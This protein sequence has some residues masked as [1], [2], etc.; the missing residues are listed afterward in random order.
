MQN[1]CFVLVGNA[2]G[3]N[4]RRLA[5][6]I[7]SGFQETIFSAR[8]SSY[9]VFAATIDL[10]ISLVCRPKPGRRVQDNKIIADFRRDSGPH[11]PVLCLVRKA[12]PPHWRIGG[13]CAAIDG[14]KIGQLPVMKSTSPS[15]R[16]PA[17]LSITIHFLPRR[18]PTEIAS[19]KTSSR[20]WP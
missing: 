15:A 13:A 2:R 6:V 16:S 8:P 18:L 10:R 17:V 19:F 12:F 7:F 1:A 14:P 20:W 9:E 4:T 11:P 3:G 5:I